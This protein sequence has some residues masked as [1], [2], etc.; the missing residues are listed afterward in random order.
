MKLN[1]YLEI[2]NAEFTL[3]YLKFTGLL[4]WLFSMH[5]EHYMYLQVINIHTFQV[6]DVNVDYLQCILGW[7]P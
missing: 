7:Y 1:L 6:E 4:K 3:G 5:S 2:Y